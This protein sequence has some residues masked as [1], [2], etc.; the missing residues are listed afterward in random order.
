M[1]AAAR[2]LLVVT[3]LPWCLEAQTSSD[4][5]RLKQLYDAHQFFELRQAVEGHTVPA[6]YAGAVAAAFGEFQ[7]GE[8]LL[9]QA[10]RNASGVAAAN[11]ARDSLISLYMVT[12]HSSAAVRVM[13]ELL[14]AAPTRTDVRNARAFVS[15]FSDQ[16]IE[17]RSSAEVEC[18]ATAEGIVLPVSINGK[19]VH[20]L[21]DTGFSNAALNESEARMLGLTVAAGG[22]TGDMQGGTAPARTAVA[23]RMTI[24]GTVLRDVPLIVYPDT[25]PPWNELPAGRR[26][27]L[28]LPVA[29]ALQTIGWTTSHTCRIG[30]ENSVAAGPRANLAF[31]DASLI[32]RARFGTRPLDFVLDTGNQGGTQLWSRFARDFP[33]LI[34][35][36]GRKSTKTVHQIGGAKQQDVVVLPEAHLAIG[37]FDA[38]LR[39]TEVFGQSVGDDVHH[40][41]MGMSVLGQAKAVT[42]DLRAMLLTLR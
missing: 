37:A 35:D 11:D 13:D 14:T 20:W 5:A 2:A 17:S 3:A 12:G 25:Q 26:G 18:S 28:G 22:V 10:A 39:P 31:D 4:P 34:R 24:G 36:Q 19:A 15:R 29:V 30:A 41:N 32:A 9:T 7:I 33:A 6:L 27:A 38:V 40:G 8:Q 23:D 1:R 16:R 21:M 42:I